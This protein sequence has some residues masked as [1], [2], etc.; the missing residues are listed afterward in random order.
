MLLAPLACLAPAKYYIVFIRCIGESSESPSKKRDYPRHGER[1][2]Q[3][4]IFSVNINML[5]TADD[6]ECNN[7]IQH[8][9]FIDHFW[10]AAR[11]LSMAEARLAPV[12]KTNFH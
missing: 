4:Q 9:L 6:R 3:L 12:L 2:Q 5:T 11:T 10:V 8:G 7:Y 1:Y